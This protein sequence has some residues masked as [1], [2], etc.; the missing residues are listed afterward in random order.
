MNQT[1]LIILIVAMFV[2]VFPL[3]WIIITKSLKKASGMQTDADIRPLGQL[4]ES[5]GTGSARIAGINH[6]HCVELSRYEN[7]YLFSVSG[8]MGGGQRVVL[9]S[10]INNMVVKRYFWFARKAVLRLHSGTKITLYGRLVKAMDTHS[11]I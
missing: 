8:L 10:E 1:Q 6:N 7:G 5:F 4:L 9:L 3:L 2:L 11:S